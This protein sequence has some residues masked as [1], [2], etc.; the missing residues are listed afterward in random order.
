MKKLAKPVTRVARHTIIGAADVF[1]REATLRKAAKTWEKF[2]RGESEEHKAARILKDKK[3]RMLKFHPSN[4]GGALFKLHFLVKMLEEQDPLLTKLQLSNNGIGPDLITCLIEPLKTNDSMPQLF[5]NFNRLGDIGLVRLMEGLR[6]NTGIRE[7]GLEQNGLTAAPMFGMA[8]WLRTNKTLTHLNLRGNRIDEYGALQLLDA[9]HENFTILKLDLRMNNVSLDL[10]RRIREVLDRNNALPGFHALEPGNASQLTMFDCTSSN[11]D[12]STGQTLSDCGATALA[13][14]LSHNNTIR[15]LRLWSN[16]VGEAGGVQLAHMFRTNRTLTSVSL[17]DNLLGDAAAIAFGE[18]FEDHN[19]VLRTVRLFKNNISD[20]GASALAAS[21]TSNAVLTVLDLG[22]NPI[23]EAGAEALRQALEKNIT[24]TALGLVKADREAAVYEE[25]R[26]VESDE[27]YDSEEERPPP[28]KIFTKVCDQ[29]ALNKFHLCDRIAGAPASNGSVL[30]DVN[31][32]YLSFDEDYLL[33][34]LRRAAMDRNVNSLDLSYTARKEGCGSTGRYHAEKAKKNPRTKTRRESCSSVPRLPEEA[35]G[36]ARRRRAS[37]DYE[38]PTKAAM[39]KRKEGEEKEEGGSH[40]NQGE[41]GDEEEQGGGTQSDED[42]DEK[43]KEEP[44]TPPPPSI[45][46][47]A[48]DPII[49]LGRV[50]DQAKKPREAILTL[51]EYL[52]S[53][54]RRKKRRQSAIDGSKVRDGC[55]LVLCCTVPSQ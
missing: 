26:V 2:L 52:D 30:H 44:H 49:E 21:L 48:T 1:S 39:Q 9:I 55:F 22:S 36:A 10:Q 47:L 20:K 13:N 31:L 51:I 5:L 46:P 41:Q 16:R 3:M 14:A 11:P 35:A 7:L 40:D 43:H 34:V 38:S 17:Q 6:L 37:I 19:R 53:Q 8:E 28:E 18:A 42:G 32:S 50:L 25:P 33:E 15:T 24:L 29:I 4:A 23:K 27:D 54:A 45:L 12:F